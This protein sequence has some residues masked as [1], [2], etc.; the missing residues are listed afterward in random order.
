[1]ANLIKSRSY[2]LD[3]L[4]HKLT[5]LAQAT[6]IG[7]AVEYQQYVDDLALYLLKS[8]I[9]TDVNAVAGKV[10]DAP[11]IKSYVDTSIS[12]LID[13]APE[14]YDTLKELADWIGTHGD[15][16]DALVVQ[17]GNK[18]DAD[19]VT[20]NLSDVAGTVPDTPTIKTALDLKVDD[21]QITTDINDVAG[22][23]PD[24]PTIKNYVETHVMSH[25]EVVEGDLATVTSGVPVIITHNRGKDFKSLLNF[26]FVNEAN[27]D[28]LFLV[29]PYDGTTEENKNK[30]YATIN[31]NLSNVHWI[32]AG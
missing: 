18:L 23:I 31:K 9:L 13:S 30:I 26:R 25:V 10:L 20:T 2:D 16:Y 28:E 4:N 5:N 15:L 32:V 3:M 12:N 27:E 22:Q 7:N 17:V 24:A 11:T 19:K 6:E 29:E 21:S 8:D 1:M 14:A